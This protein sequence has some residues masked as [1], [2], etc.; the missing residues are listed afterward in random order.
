MP[1]LTSRVTSD[2]DRGS[3]ATEYGFLVAFIALALIIG[4]TF[5]GSALGNWF[6]QLASSLHLT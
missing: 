2:D 1:K 5:F 3:T 4:I 6:S